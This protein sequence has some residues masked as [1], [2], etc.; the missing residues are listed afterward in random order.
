[1]PD[2]TALQALAAPAGFIVLWSTGY[3]AGRVAIDYAAPF[4]TLTWR[5]G[6]ATLLFA[7]VAMVR[8]PVAWPSVRE[9]WHS[10]VVGLLTL[11]LQFGGVYAAFQLGAS[12][13]FAALAIGSMPL[14]VSVTA[15]SLGTRQP[16]G[17]WLG[18]LLGFAGVTLVLQDR[19]GSGLGSPAAGIAL[20]LGLCGITFG[21]LY[22]KRYAVATDLTASLFIQNLVATL[23]VAPV[24]LLHEHFRATPAPAFI[25]S[26]LWLVLVNS[27]ATFALLFVLL[28]RGAATQVSTL[29]YLVT[30]VTAVMG[31]LLMG[32]PM[33]A[34]KVGG[35]ALAAAGVYIGTRNA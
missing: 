21:T 2:F 32:E 33:S 11:A 6:G 12:S 27:G 35:F 15:A 31:W 28:R 4:T 9:A 17:H 30:P 20:L 18:L 24:A 25:A 22:Q 5:F 26:M 16:V 29:F 13:G 10:A 8:R 14:A 23:A 7:L 3:I 1:M 34:I 19:L